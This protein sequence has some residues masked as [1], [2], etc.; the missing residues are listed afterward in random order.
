MRIQLCN[1]GADGFFA[2]YRL[3]DRTAS[4]QR[5][6]LKI[7]LRNQALGKGFARKG[8]MNMGWTPVADLVTPG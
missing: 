1:Q 7:H 8:K 5:I 6:A 4:Y 2:A 3:Q